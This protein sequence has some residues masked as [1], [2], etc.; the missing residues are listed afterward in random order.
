M[1]FDEKVLKSDVSRKI[2]SLITFEMGQAGYQALLESS[3]DFADEDERA[4][5]ALSEMLAAAS[6]EFRVAL[7]EIFQSK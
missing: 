1:L 2:Y 6:Y 4:K 7:C 3:G 5:A